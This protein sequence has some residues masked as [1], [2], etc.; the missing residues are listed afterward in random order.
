VNA[1]GVVGVAAALI[2]SLAGCNA[3]SSGADSGSNWKPTRNVTIEVPFAPGGGSDVFGR[4]LQKGIKEVR[5]G[6][7]VTVENRAGGNG[8]VGYSDFFTKKDNPYYLLPSETVGVALPITTKTPWRWTNFTP[9]MQ[10]A[11]DVNLLIVPKDSPYTDLKSVV[12][13]GKQGKRMR[14]GITGATSV[15]G[16]DTSMMERDQGISFDGVTFDSGGEEVAGILG[17]NIDMAMLNPSEVIG[18]INAGKVRAIAVFAEDRYKRAPLD[19]VPTA[20]EQGVNVSFTQYRG[21]FATGGITAAQ[22][23]YWADTIAKWTQSPSYKNY[24][25][26]NYLNPVQRNH[27]EFVSYLKDYQTQLESILKRK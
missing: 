18:Q 8:A 1:T 24:V 4:A 21:V 11:E 16:V 17:G 27:D 12:A 13:A 23:K 6:V 20:K 15:D 19:A 9:I 26:S 7:N 14:M 2:G 5:S 22:Q 3:D 25:E 10:I